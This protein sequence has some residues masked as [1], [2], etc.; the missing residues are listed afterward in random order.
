MLTVYNDSNTPISLAVLSATA[1]QNTQPDTNAIAAYTTFTKSYELGSYYITATDANNTVR[2]APNPV[3]LAQ[4]GRKLVFTGAALNNEP[5]NTITPPTE[6]NE[7]ATLT[8][9]YVAA[10]GVTDKIVSARVD[11]GGQSYTKYGV[12]NSGSTVVFDGLK[13]DGQTQYTVTLKL[14]DTSNNNPRYASPAGTITLI[15]N[16]TL[17][18][19]GIVFT[20]NNNVTIGGGNPTRYTVTYQAGRGAGNVPTAQQVNAGTNIQLPNQG[21][22][23]PPQGENFNGWQD[24]NQGKSI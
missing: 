20:G 3:A 1:L 22:M 23:I 11:A 10:G 8:I 18:Y 14:V 17:T 7:A 13:A 16:G 9:S 2:Q 4:A 12:V 15:T 6:A 19:N 24:N 21:N 5:G